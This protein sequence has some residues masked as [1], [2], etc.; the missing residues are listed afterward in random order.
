MMLQSLL[1]QN[2]MK[3]KRNQVKIS[4]KDSHVIHRDQ[5][6]NLISTAT[7]CVDMTAVDYLT[8]N[9]C[10]IAEPQPTDSEEALAS[11]HAKEWKT[12]AE[13]EYQSLIENSLVKL[14]KG[15]ETIG[16]KWG[17]SIPAMEESKGLKGDWGPNG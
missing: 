6:G 2:Q 11:N 3:W 14:P 9:V 8:F 4:I 15:R 16:C 12:A 10:E 17:F 5:E 7:E 1:S 13:A